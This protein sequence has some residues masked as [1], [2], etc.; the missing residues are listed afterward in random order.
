M[1]TSWCRGT[2]MKE[3]LVFRLGD[4]AGGE[5]GTLDEG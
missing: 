5:G 2:Q 4:E 1:K 3:M